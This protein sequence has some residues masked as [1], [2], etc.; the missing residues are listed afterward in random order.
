MNFKSFA[1]IKMSCTGKLNGGIFALFSSY[2]LKIIYLLP[3]IFLWRSFA[4]NGADLGGFTLAQL[5]TYTCVS[6]ML[7]QQL[8][9]WTEASSWNY[10]GR[11][12]NLYTHP[13]TV[14]AQIIFTT[15]GGWVPE[16]LMFS[17]PMAVILPFFGVN[18]IPATIWFLPCLILSIS[19]GFAVDTL[20][21]CLAIRMK[22]SEWQISC[23]RRAVSA[24]LSGAVIPFALLPFGMG[25][26]FRF[27][28]FG[29]IASAPLTLFVGTINSS[30]TNLAPLNVILL[31]VLWNIILWSLAILVFG[32]S[33]ERIVSY[34]G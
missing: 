4:E 17:L 15:I 22:N 6:S 23:L 8:N 21:V 5:L 18:I 20:F 1:T 29:S 10:D 7:S 34:G 11:L 19:L 14:L 24:V 26:V 16:L 27:L 3:M 31:Q 13:Q 30:S 33:R 9:V 12:I 2:L 32:K 25:T 28:P